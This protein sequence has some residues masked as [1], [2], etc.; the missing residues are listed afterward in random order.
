MR[1]FVTGGS[2][3][4]G[5]RLISALKARGH[6]VRALAR[7]EQAM[8]AV[9]AAGAQPIEGD[10]SRIESLTAGMEG[11]EW[12]FHSAARIFGNKRSEFIEDNLRGTERVLEAARTAGVKRLIHISSESAVLGNGPLVNVDETRPIPE[13]GLGPYSHS[14]GRAEALVLACNGA[15]METVAVRPPMIWGAGD[16]TSLPKLKQAALDGRFRWIGGGRQRVS[17]CHVDNVV[18]GALLAAEKGRGGHTYFLT[19]GEPLTFRDFMSQQLQAVGVPPPRANLPFWVARLVAVASEAVWNVAF[20]GQLPLL[21]R[22]R[23]L[24]AGA[25]M[26]VNDAK[27]RAELGYLP[28]VT[29]DQGLAALR[30]SAGAGPPR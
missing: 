3:F 29:R 22:E 11:C 21:Y 12:V 26:T 27:A 6:A 16:T 20:P 7:S 9:G 14:K 4:L 24:L 23:M 30:E 18:H 10:L 25:E 19:D 13:Q 1:V 17:T 8:K 28:P 15:G 2:G 5:G